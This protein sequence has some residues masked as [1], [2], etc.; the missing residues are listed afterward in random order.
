MMKE[1]VLEELNWRYATKKFDTLKKL[2][3]QQIDGLLTAIQLAP[4]SYGL[5]PF[6]VLVVSNPAIREQL[7]AA[8]Y[9]QTQVTD[10]SELLVFATFVNYTEAHVDEYAANIIDTRGIKFAEIEEFVGM[11]KGSVKSQNQE[12]LQVWNT[13]QAYIALGFLLQT[14]ALHGIDACPMEGFDAA[15]FDEILGLA[16]KNLKAVVIAPIGFRANDD[17]YQHYKK[18]RKTKE[19]LFINV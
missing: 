14:A 4:T 3:P 17:T 9:G 7:K 2:T 16:N 15:K 6:K 13:T 18:V 5:Q 19:N 1:L 11:M 12:Q 8:A 10:A